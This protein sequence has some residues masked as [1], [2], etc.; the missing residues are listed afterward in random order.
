MG[1]ISSGVL[2][3][4]A[5]VGLVA[6]SIGGLSAG[7]YFAYQTGPGGGDGTSVPAGA[8]VSASP[9][10][11]LAT[12]TPTTEPPTPQPTPT[13]TALPPTEA[14]PAPTA[15]AEPTKWP[16]LP[17]P[18]SRPENP[19]GAARGTAD[20]GQWYAYGQCLSFYLP[21][22]YTF[23]IHT[24]VNDP[25]GVTSIAFGSLGTESAVV[26]DSD[27]AQEL[28]RTVLEGSLGPVFDQIAATI[29]RDC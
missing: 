2:A 16:A 27:T 6:V 24:A 17:P 4:L 1:V 18:P 13:P 28:G 9:T 22:G 20:G 21:G 12:P 15:T 7:A 3:G 29:S 19:V 11:P 5:K 14:P 23:D 10:A 25:G 26:F 8:T